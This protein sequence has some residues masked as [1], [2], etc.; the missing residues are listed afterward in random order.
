MAKDKGTKGKKDEAAAA[1]DGKTPA[2]LGGHPRASR[3]LLRGRGWGGLL[4]FLLVAWLS[5][6]AGAP[7][8]DVALRALVGGTV[9]ALAGW[10]A[11]VVAWRALASAEI[12]AAHRAFEQAV[13][14][15]AEAH[16]RQRAA[17]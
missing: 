4:G 8:P 6:R 3:D 17:A 15:H 10:A 11:A 2:T 13:K 16:E 9:G 14:V 12:R 5:H 7:L 1:A